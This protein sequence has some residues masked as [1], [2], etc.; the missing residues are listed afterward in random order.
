M[1]ETALLGLDAL[2]LLPVIALGCAVV[3]E[4]DSR[5]SSKPPPPAA[6]V[7]APEIVRNKKASMT[8]KRGSAHENK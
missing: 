8:T 1:S 2:A 7:S 4:A 5:G 3:A 6:E